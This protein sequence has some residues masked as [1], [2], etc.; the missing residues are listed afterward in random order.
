MEDSGPP[1]SK[2]LRPGVRGAWERDIFLGGACFFPSTSREAAVISLQLG[3][4]P[5]L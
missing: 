1:E 5:G 3:V 4:W 2:L